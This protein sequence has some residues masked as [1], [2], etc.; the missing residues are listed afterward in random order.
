MILGFKDSRIRL[1]EYKKPCQFRDITHSIFNQNVRRITNLDYFLNFLYRLESRVDQ[2]EKRSLN[3]KTSIK[4]MRGES[5][6]M[7]RRVEELEDYA[8]E[9]E[10]NFTTIEQALK[11]T[12]RKI[13]R[14]N[15]KEDEMKKKDGDKEDEITNSNQKDDDTAKKDTDKDKD[16]KSKKEDKPDSPEKQ[17]STDKPMVKEVASLKA[18]DGSKEEKASSAKNDTEEEEVP[19]EISEEIS[20]EV[21]EDML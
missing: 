4:E 7:T 15:E 3:N 21:H 14:N 17:I 12:R 10:Q 11:E 2:V 1:Y 19:E 6:E 18:T 5:V 20:E 8:D 16:T 13:R 9:T